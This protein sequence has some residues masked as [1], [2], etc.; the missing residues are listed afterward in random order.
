MATDIRTILDQSDFVTGTKIPSNDLKNMLKSPNR[1]WSRFQNYPPTP[2]QVLNGRRYISGAPTG[3]PGDYSKQTAPLKTDGNIDFLYSPS[4]SIGICQIQSGKYKGKF[5][6]VFKNK[7]N[8]QGF[9]LPGGTAGNSNQDPE[10]VYKS[11]LYREF[12]EECGITL[13]SAHPIMVGN[14]TPR[15][16]HS[17]VV[18]K[19]KGNITN[20]QREQDKD[21]SI[22]YLTWDELKIALSG[23]L[24]IDPWI[25][26]FVR[27]N[28]KELRKYFHV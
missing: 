19:C 27:T 15:L 5:V 20:A 26:P 24:S 28:E 4:A 21:L 10:T 12:L 1:V 14:P 23:E 8:L 25:M 3:D 13:T 6:V 17:C 16:I 9:A 7:A 2:F 18:F 22:A 11:A